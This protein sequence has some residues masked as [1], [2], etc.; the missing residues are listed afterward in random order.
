MDRVWKPEKS[1]RGK[2][3]LLEQDKGSVAGDFASIH[4]VTAPARQSKLNEH[5]K[6]E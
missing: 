2:L 3:D 5:F 1:I 6:N 4:N